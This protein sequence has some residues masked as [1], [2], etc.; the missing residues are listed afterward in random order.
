[1]YLSNEELKNSLKEI[2]SY[3][4]S[5][6]VLLDCYSEFAAKMSKYKNPVKDVGVTT[7]YGL[8]EPKLLESEA[9]S[10]VCEHEMTPKALIEQFIGMEKCI[11]EK[12]YA[13]RMAKSLYKLFEYEKKV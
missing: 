10:F 12:L 1:M 8:K 4:S 6:C 13:G 9:L 2:S 3:F 5:V 7:V 11:F